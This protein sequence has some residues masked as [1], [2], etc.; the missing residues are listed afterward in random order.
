[1]RARITDDP[2]P[3]AET[4]LQSFDVSF[5]IHAESS[6][7]N[8]ANGKFAQ[9]AKKLALAAGRVMLKYFDI[10]QHVK[11]KADNSPVTIADTLINEIVIKEL[12]KQFPLDGIIG[13]ERSTSTYG[14]GRKWICDP[15]DGTAGYVWGTPT[16]MFSLGLVVDGKP[17]L[18]VAY[19]PFLKRMYHG[20][21]KK[22]AYCNDKKIKV[23]KSGLDKGVM[24][25]SSSLRKVVTAEYIK[26]A[27]LLKKEGVLF[28]TFSGAV[29]KS[30]L[31]AKGKFVGYVEQ[32]LSPYDVAAAQVIVEEA[33]GK[34][35]GLIGE[36]LD[37]SK[38]FKGAVI[39]N[40]K[41]HKKLIEILKRAA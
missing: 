36:K 2:A 19:D 39:S 40:G 38:V 37:Y 18:G 25:L 26:Y 23:S 8:N 21:H 34:V 35:T 4:V 17:V 33:G 32:G 28:A 15:I 22:G 6:A 27:D 20:I 31:V 14:G 13:E 29:Y 12:Q 5:G 3:C 10:D 30:I 41:V 9:V 7:R 11:R 16:A 1:M 24:A